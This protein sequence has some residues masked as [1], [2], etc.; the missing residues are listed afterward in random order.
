MD[1]QRV[2]VLACP[3]W[4]LLAAGVARDTPAV[5]IEANRVT[6][7]TP[8][9]AA[10][11][12][13]VGLRRR[14]AETRC[15]TLVISKPDP[16]REAREFEKIL[17]ALDGFTPFIEI[18]RPGTCLFAT[19]ACARYFGGEESLAAQ[20][21]AAITATVR[22]ERCFGLG[23]ADG[24]FA[25]SVA[26]RRSLRAGEPVIVEPGGS[27]EF[28]AP[29]PVALLG[30]PDLADLLRRLG[31]KTLGAFAA[32]PSADVLGRFG[33]DGI[34]AHR[35]AGG[36]D[37]HRFAPRENQA[38]MELSEELD[39]PTDRSD[40]AVFAGKGL[41]DRLAGQ[42]EAE[43]LACNKVVIE[44][45]TEDGQTFSRTWRLDGGFSPGAI[46][47]R[48]R[49][50]LDG[51]LTGGAGAATGSSNARPGSAL[52][53]ITIVP[54]EVTAQ[55]GVQLSFW[56]GQT[57]PGRRAAR[58]IARLQ[59]LLGP[60]AVV[61]PE[62]RGG[63]GPDDRFRLVPADAVDLL[64]RSATP[65]FL[66]E[67]PWPGHVPAPSPALV[68]SDRRNVGLLDGNGKALAV[69]GDKLTASPTTVTLGAG[70]RLEVTGWAGPWPVNER[71]WDPKAS[72]RLVRMQVACADNNAYLVAFEAGR[73][74]LEA[75]YD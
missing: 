20:V 49:W 7:G 47:Q 70:R 17:G 16:A 35:Q 60:E 31:L 56:G 57:E 11:G 50:Q 28:L 66:T 25:A 69:D 45:T 13:L 75:A 52:A 10:V 54:E 4:P 22:Q 6:V 3:W 19:R 34:A 43:G 18:L 12:V 23:I 73:W 42:L 74:W 53:R 37:E 36:V 8:G 46:A 48:M 39:P 26:A 40:I 63:R 27:P 65:D 32:L 29:Q 33:H 24:L 14:E 51:W 15:P 67:A 58:G 68:F 5:V 59:G 2:L 62:Y 61:V 38:V 21:L 9:A 72:R 55:P 71:W 1:S 30:R 64:N 44:A 41:A